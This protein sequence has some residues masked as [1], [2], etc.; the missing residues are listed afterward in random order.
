MEAAAEE[1]V[2][3]S[4]VPFADDGA[5]TDDVVT[6]TDIDGRSQVDTVWTDA[7]RRIYSDV[8]TATIDFIAVPVQCTRPDGTI[9]DIMR[10]GSRRSRLLVTSNGCKRLIGKS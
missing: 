5:L 3:G 8:V 1:V 10:R 7:V 9:C 4:V 2:Q 6:T